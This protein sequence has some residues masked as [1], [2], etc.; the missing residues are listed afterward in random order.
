MLDETTQHERSAATPKPRA[1]A[2]PLSVRVLE[3][4]LR[5]WRPTGTAVAVGLA[6]MLSWHVV[7]GKHG[8]SVEPWVAIGSGASVGALGRF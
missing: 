1:V 8:L 6:L 2:V 5:A 3:W 4:L 7:N